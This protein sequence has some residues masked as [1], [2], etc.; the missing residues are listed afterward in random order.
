MEEQQQTDENLTAADE[1]GLRL[2]ARFDD[3]K[4]ERRDYEDRW[5]ENLR[6]YRGEYGPD[7]SIPKNR[8]QA[9]LRLTRIKVRAMDSRILDMLFPSGRT[10]S[11]KIEA[12][13]E[14]DVDPEFLAEVATRYEQ[15]VGQQP[16]EE[17]LQKLVREHARESAE[18]MERLIKDQL[19]E[20]RYKS[21]CRQVFHSGHLFGTGVLK[22]PMADYKERTGYRQIGTNEYE[23]Y[24]ET[25]TT[26]YFEPVRIWDI[27]PDMSV[28]DVEDADYVFQRHVMSRQELRGLAKRQDF[29]AQRIID[30]LKTQPEGDAQPMYWEDELKNVNPQMDSSKRTINRKYE[31]LEYW[32]YVDGHDLIEAGVDIEDENVEYQANVWVLG[33][34]TIKAVLAPYDSQRLPYYFYYYEKDD[35]SIF[36]IGVPEIGE[37]TQ[38]LANSANR[39]MIDNAAIAV[40]PQGEANLDLLDPSEDPRDIHPMK[41]WLR[42]GRGADAQYPAIKFFSPPNHTKDLLNMVETFRVWNDEV[43]G[44]PSYMHGDSDVS[45]AGK[46]ASGLSMLMGAANLTMKDAVENFDCGITVPFLKEMYSWNMKYSDD[47]K[48]KGDYEVKATGSTSLVAKEVRVG[49]LQNFMQMTANEMDQ[50]LVDRRN[51][52]ETILKEMELPEHILRPEEETDYIKQLEQALQQMQQQMQVVQQQMEG[53]GAG[54]QM[55]EMQQASWQN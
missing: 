27:Y 6:M 44:I 2:A 5:L 45:G 39:A 42:K 55:R 26:P 24:R 11:F 9:F 20:L 7:V 40:G 29:D 50:P 25:Q 4:S 32:G 49:N 14:P 51:M 15:Q 52:L 41:I 1:L 54:D 8:S 10:E 3:C 17:E 46:T 34:R 22:G 48:I 47:E 30:Y 31:I 53:A 35:T 21:A 37:D 38:D 33:G 43:T 19:S 23:F 12:T 28:M 13:P 18:A 16:S 36:G